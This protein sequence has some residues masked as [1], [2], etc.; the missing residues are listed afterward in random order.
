MGTRGSDVVKR[1][2]SCQLLRAYPPVLSLSLSLN[3]R[4][5]FQVDF[6]FVF[7]LCFSLSPSVSFSFA[8][9]FPLTVLTG[10]L[11]V[12]PAAASRLTLLFCF[13]F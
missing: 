8:S 2:P 11:L 10:Y 1:D 13:F 3:L 6:T 4:C 9:H 5:S 12:S 7:C